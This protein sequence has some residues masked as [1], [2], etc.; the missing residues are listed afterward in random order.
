[1]HIAPDSIRSSTLFASAKLGALVGAAFL[2]TCAAA[3]AQTAYPNKVVK[4]VAAS[5]PGG[6]TDSVARLLA[7]YLSQTMGQQFIVENRAG[8]GNVR[9]SEFVAHAA[10][11][12]YTLLMSASTLSMNHVM[13]KKLP[14]DVARDFAPITQMV[15]LPNVLVVD[16]RLPYRTLADFIAAAKKDPEAL[17]Y[18]SA[19]L[20]TQPHLAM[21]LLQIMAGIKLT[22]VPYTGVGPA[23]LDIIGG[24]VTGMSVNFLSAKPQIAAGAL[25]ALAISSLKRSVFAPDL[26]TIDQ[27]GVPGYEAIQWFGLLAPGGTPSAIIDKL[28]TE[29]KKVL[30][31]P[32]MK[33]RLALE[34]AEAVGGTPAEFAALIKAEMV[35]WGN[36]ATTAGIQP[37]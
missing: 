29:T 37:E 8:A 23:L 13:Y 9:G 18:G 5:A 1:M 34:G 33:Q 22:H 21:E 7:A 12:G 24:R 26:P 3:H 4:I 6:G 11:D 19:G 2:L 10:P 32:S 25:R 17:T 20:G 35:K 30:E 27:S 16:P 14:Y 15:A 28:N 36:V 31:D